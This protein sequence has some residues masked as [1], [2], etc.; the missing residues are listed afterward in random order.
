MHDQTNIRMTAAEIASLWSQYMDDSVT[1]CVLKFFLTNTENQRVKEI[2]IKAL[3]ASRSNLIQ[4]RKIFD[5]EHFPYPIAFS[6]EDVNPSSPKLF[7]DTYYLVYLR[8][9]SMLGMAASCGAIALSTRPDI[10]SFHKKV[11][12]SSLILNDLA[13]DLMIE[14]GSYVR[15]PFLLIP[16]QVEFVDHP[17]FLKGLFKNKKRPLTALEITHLVMNIQNNQVGKALIMGF[18]Q[19]AE[20]HDVKEFLLRGKKIA[21]KHI[22]LFSNILIES[23]VPAPMSWDSEVTDSTTKAFSDKLI[24]FHIA[25]MISAGI[26][27]Y[28]AGIAATFRSDIAAQYMTLL[29]E[30][31][32][33]AEDGATLMIKNGWLEEPPMTV[34]RNSLSKI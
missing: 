10:I 26:G 30:I 14:Q 21:Q 29:P 28:G 27:N 8:H 3:E 25:A 15:P 20:N 13:R 5:G 34:D 12:E 2:V 1:S 9:M 23:D 32:L 4:I 11:L 16:K 18:L 6:D 31:S 33:Y 19:T 22:D 17:R 7:S 24:M